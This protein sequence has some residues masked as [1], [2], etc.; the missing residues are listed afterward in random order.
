MAIV[1]NSRSLEWS[2]TNRLF[3]SASLAITR[4]QS[5]S[6]S[7]SLHRAKSPTFRKLGRPHEKD[8]VHEDL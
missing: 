3:L 6:S 2:S 1:R 4:S 5:A 7:R 8:L